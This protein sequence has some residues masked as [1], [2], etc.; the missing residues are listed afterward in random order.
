MG[1]PVLLLLLLLVLMCPRAI[2]R[3]IGCAIWA[4]IGVIAVCALFAH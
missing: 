3:G 4:V 1:H 2:L